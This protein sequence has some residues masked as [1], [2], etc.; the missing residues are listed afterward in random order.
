MTPKK[1]PSGNYRALVFIGIVDGKRKYKS[2]TAPTY[3]ECK[4]KAAAVLT[5]RK[6]E[7][8][9]PTIKKICED[10]IASKE[11]VL[12]PS[13][14]RGYSTIMRARFHAVMERPASQVKD[15]QKVISA[16]SQNCSAKTIKNAWGFVSAALKDAGITVV[17]VSNNHGDRIELFNRTLGLDAYADCKKPGKKKL[18]EIMKTVGATTDNSAFLGD[19][20]FTDVLSARNLGI[21]IALLVPPIKDKLTL[22][23]RFKRWMEKPII[24]KYYKIHGG[25]GK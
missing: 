14:V 15:W 2:V 17:L 10:Y 19:Q 8:A 1:L 7:S 12:S 22:F 4:I 23:F 11:P 6:Q 24:R 18:G 21:K 13:T 5:N 25:D 16:E 9:D 20:I 3:S